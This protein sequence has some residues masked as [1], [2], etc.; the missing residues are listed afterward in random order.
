MAFDIEKFKTL[1]PEAQRIVFD[2]KG[3]SSE[4]QAIILQKI[5]TAPIVG[6]QV[7]T[8]DT[9]PQFD[10][11]GG[12]PVQQYTGELPQSLD[13]ALGVP[14]TAAAI[15]T[16][17][18]AAAMG[19]VGSIRKKAMGASDVEA[20]Q[21]REALTEAYTYKPRTESGKAS[22]GL[23]GKATYPIA[24]GLELIGEYGGE[25]A[26]NI[27]EAVMFMVAP[28]VPES[29]KSAVKSAKKARNIGLDMKNVDV[30]NKRLDQMIDTRLNKAIRPSVAGKTTFPKMRT[31]DENANAAIKDMVH[32]KK[33]NSFERKGK[34]VEGENPKTLGESAKVLDDNLRK[35]ATRRTDLADKAGESP[36]YVDGVQTGSVLNEIIT[37][38]RK[39]PKSRAD[40]MEIQD[41]VSGKEL[42]RD[43]AT[44]EVVTV[45]RNQK[46]TPLQGHEL[47]SELNNQARAWYKN[48]D[49]HSKA[50]LAEKAAQQLRQDM[51]NSLSKAGPEYKALGQN[52]RNYMSIEKDLMNRWQ[53]DKRNNT[54]GF[55]DLGNLMT[56]IE[57]SKGGI[58]TAAAIQA[59]KKFMKHQNKPN[60]QI[61]RM[62]RETE[63]MLNVIDRKTPPAFSDPWA[64]LMVADSPVIPKTKQRQIEWKPEFT[65]T[66]EQVSVPYYGKGY[67]AA[68]KSMTGAEV[69][70][71]QQ[72]M[73][74]P[75]QMDAINKA[76]K[77]SPIAMEVLEAQGRAT[78]RKPVVRNMVDDARDAL[79]RVV[80]ENNRIGRR[81]TEVQIE[82]IWQD[83]LNKLEEIRKSPQGA[84][85]LK[86]DL[87]AESAVR[88][89]GFRRTAE[90]KLDIREQPPNP[91]LR[92]PP[93]GLNGLQGRSTL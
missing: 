76:I 55:F 52:M 63:R 51:V 56:A 13:V 62:F 71:A 48:P 66:G 67:K 35:D 77:R 53:V 19:L 87:A 40:A 64:E 44:G 65:E 21:Y 90:Q 27:T 86:L 16:G 81:M 20:K 73:V 75:T 33:L 8:P 5:G 14:E 12:F 25:S 83:G 31:F 85:L 17:V 46:M 1:S 47:A 84:E 6:S 30:L 69:K 54:Y 78:A 50:Y 80:A 91:S 57:L 74:S 3:I 58:T 28:R 72:R 93:I 26:R 41:W 70:A 7:A 43:S 34:I 39:Y 68:P 36:V 38:P 32:N 15:A 88:T 89:P 60:T 22:V 59:T 9:T 10:Q 18:P 82:S 2:K 29:V 23:I 45:Y 79:V 11:A 37:N 61:S 24:K 4:A 92:P 49:M 42:V